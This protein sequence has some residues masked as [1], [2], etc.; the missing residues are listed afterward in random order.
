M[1][2]LEWM[3]SVAVFL[4][5][6]VELAVHVNLHVHV[7]SRVITAVDHSALWH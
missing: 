1:H 5:V 2:T 7:N 3:R 6:Q 4:A